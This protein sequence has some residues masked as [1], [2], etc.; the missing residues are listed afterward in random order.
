MQADAVDTTGINKQLK[1]M[2]KFFPKKRLLN[3]P[4]CPSREQRYLSRDGIIST[5]PDRNTVQGLVDIYFETFEQTH[6]LF[7]EA[8]FK[9]G[10]ALFWDN[11]D[12][13]EP[14]WLA[15]LFL[16]LALSCHASRGTSAENPTPAYA[17][18]VEA[19]LES[20][21]AALHLTGF[22]LKPS[23]ESLR[24]LCIV[25]IGKALDIVRDSQSYISG[26]CLHV[27][28]ITLDDSD[29]LYIFTGFIVRYAFLLGMHRDP[30][31]ATG[32]PAPEA[33]ARRKIWTTI[34]FLDL[35]ISIEVCTVIECP[36][37]LYLTPTVRHA[38]SHSFN[39]L[40][41]L[42][43][44]RYVGRTRLRPAARVRY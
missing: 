27:L 5:L 8:T 44:T 16:M 9:E 12:S 6:A 24:A 38:P 28:Q 35:R 13:V 30:K 26:T 34:L 39:G 3:Y 29:T 2:K 21:Q 43:T 41:H 23:L 7:H 19:Y 32:M 1:G 31:Y 40:R 36:K 11:S 14:G 42:T 17:G 10:L 4:F 33:Q 22:M 15:S 18:Q 25:A 37:T 20:A